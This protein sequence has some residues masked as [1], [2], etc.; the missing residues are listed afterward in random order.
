MKKYW[1]A[2][3]KELLIGNIGAETLN[4]LTRKKESHAFEQNIC[5]QPEVAL[6]CFQCWLVFDSVDR[7]QL[8]A[9]VLKHNS[10]S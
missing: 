10:D 2:S 7:N 3:L 4:N 6:G 5:K 8:L 1:T 9:K